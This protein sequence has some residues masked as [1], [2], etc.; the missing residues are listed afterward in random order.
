MSDVYAIQA[1]TLT[2]LG[3]AIRSHV[4]ETEIRDVPCTSYL[5]TVIGGTHISTSPLEIPVLGATTITLSRQGGAG[6]N[7]VLGLK[8]CTTISGGAAYVFDD[9]ITL[10]NFTKE[11]IG[12]YITNGGYSYKTEV[13]WYDADGNEMTVI[14]PAEVKKTMTVARMVEEVNGMP[15]SLTAEELIFSGDCSYL[16]GT[17]NWDNVIRKFG[18]MITTKDITDMSYICAYTDLTSIPFEINAKSTTACEADYAFFRAES[19]RVAPKINNLKPSK[20]AAL[21]EN[22]YSLRTLPD[23]WADNWDWTSINTATSGSMTNIF[24][25]CYSLRTIPESFLNNLYNKATSTLYS[26]YVSTFTSCY[27]LDEIRGLAITPATPTRNLFSSSFDNCYRLKDLTF[28]TNEDGSAKTANWS[29]QLIDLTV[30]VGVTPV[31][32]GSN[33]AYYMTN[34]NSGITTDKEVKDA[35]TYAALKNDP[36]WYTHDNS[37]SRYNHD[38]AVN[39]INS[40]PDCSAGSGNVIKF[41]GSKGSL[42]DG[43]AINTLTEEEIAVAAAKGWTVTLV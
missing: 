25:Y 1:S 21:F 34:W 16:C 38:S 35:E 28:A 17:G 12:L 23:D 29:N 33:K 13:K 2:A 8:N 5:F 10:T 4:G 36:D 7:T 11:V 37:Y 20:L 30:N 22:C 6:G 19:L 39:T 31:Y 26:G 42:T 14:F 43:G 40:L 9:P 3:D 32:G 41:S 24:R 27:T 18:N 15:E